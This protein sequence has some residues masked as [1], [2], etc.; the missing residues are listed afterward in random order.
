MD[1]A[2]YFLWPK[3]TINEEG[4][5]GIIEKTEKHEKSKGP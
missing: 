3:N 2:H 1:Y 5:R 4:V